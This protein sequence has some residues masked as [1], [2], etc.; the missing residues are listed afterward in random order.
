MFAFH[1][2]GRGLILDL[3]DL[4]FNREQNMFASRIRSNNRSRISAM[5]GTQKIP[6]EAWNIFGSGKISVDMIQFQWGLRF[7]YRKLS[8]IF[9][10]LKFRL[11]TNNYI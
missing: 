7:Q 1:G 11:E 9:N 10:N 8:K 2:I 4:A 5:S 3:V 6:I